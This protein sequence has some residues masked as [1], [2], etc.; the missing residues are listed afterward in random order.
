MDKSKKVGDSKSPLNFSSMTSRIQRKFANKFKSK[1]KLVQPLV[2]KWKRRLQSYSLSEV[3]LL[4]FCIL[5]LYLV[6]PDFIVFKK[7]S[8]VKCGVMGLLSKFFLKSTLVR[9]LRG[10]LKL[11]NVLNPKSWDPQTCLSLTVTT[12][13]VVFFINNIVLDQW[14]HYNSQKAKQKLVDLRMNRS[15]CQKISPQDFDS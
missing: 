4:L 15:K 2:S 7:I 14:N 11:S 12:I 5:S 9:A 6:N 13:L 10:E 8:D 1:R 3:A